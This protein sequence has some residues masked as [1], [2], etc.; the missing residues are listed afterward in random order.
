MPDNLLSEKSNIIDIL[1]VESDT[2]WMLD[3]PGS[4]GVFIH[5]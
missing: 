5:P 3:L 4:F 1:L 2:M